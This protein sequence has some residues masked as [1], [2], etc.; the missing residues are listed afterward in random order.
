MLERGAAV[1][2]PGCGAWGRVGGVMAPLFGQKA[3]G[4]AAAAGDP[5]PV[6]R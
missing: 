5:A 4:P 1:G 3:P 6:V 2:R